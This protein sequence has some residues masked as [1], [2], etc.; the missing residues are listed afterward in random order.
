MLRPGLVQPGYVPI[1]SAPI[2]LP[3]ARAPETTMPVDFRFL[4]WMV[5]VLAAVSGVGLVW[6]WKSVDDHRVRVAIMRRFGERFVLEFARPLCR[7]ATAPPIRSRLR[8]GR[9]T[10]EILIAPAGG[11]RY[12]NLVDHIKNVEYD[13]ERVL[14]L[15]KDDAAIAGPL[16]SEGRWVVIPCRFETDR[17]QEG[18]M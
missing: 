12:P 14:C 9:R 13:V 5:P 11:R 4:W 15:L 7:N 8:F 1:T 2:L 16:Y 18:A 17:Q 3:Q 10:I 6:G